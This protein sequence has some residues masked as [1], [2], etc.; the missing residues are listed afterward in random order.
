MTSRDRTV[1][2]LGGG[3]MQLP[4]IEAARGLEAY[5]I[6]ADGNESAPGKA[7]SDQF[8]HID[9]KDVEQLLEAAR[10][11]RAT[12]G[13]DAVFTAG[14][15]F[16]SSVSFVAERLGLPCTPYEC[17]MDATDKFRMRERLRASGVRVPDFALVADE[18]LAEGVPD[19]VRALGLPCVV[20]PADSMGARGVVRADTWEDVDRYL[21]IAVS[22]SR[23]RRAVV[24]GYIDGPEFSL[25]AIVY[26]DEIQ[27]TG[28]ADRNICFPP[29]FI[30][31]GHTIPTTLSASEQSAVIAEFKKGIRAL[32]L[33]PGAAKGDM[34][35]SSQGPVVGEIANR[36]S[37]GYMSGW[38]YPYSSGVNLSEVGLRVA[39]GEAPGHIVASLNNTSAERA[40][41][42]IPGVVKSIDVPENTR[43]HADVRE[44]FVTKRVGDLVRF[45]QNN[46]EKVGNVISVHKDRQTAV[47][48]AERAVSSIVVVLEADREETDAF[49]FGPSTNETQ[50]WAYESVADE[51]Y[52]DHRHRDDRGAWKSILNEQGGRRE[53]VS[54]AIPDGMLDR[55]ER[56]WT[57]RTLKETLE[58]VQTRESID[59]QRAPSGEPALID[60]LFMRA[61]LRGGVQ[62]ALYV[63]Q[64]LRND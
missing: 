49:L 38:T 62:G 34:K 40:I 43:S 17:A 39:L 59:V 58:T 23:S 41:I 47:K 27:I 53:S 35:L 60:L 19:R 48:S 50:Y 8:L 4:A 54:F 64:S 11:I 30:E 13:L 52:P 1:L 33:G 31:T 57:Y 61:T 46:V 14:T 55:S 25:D 9:L 63:I 32:N 3:T 29:F 21:E 37:G 7:V 36:L 26:G 12:R 24:E 56:D 44:I 5:V 51:L 20:K 22:Y 45:P 42:S 2:I 15:D 18:E 10:E 6:V 16:S 28:F